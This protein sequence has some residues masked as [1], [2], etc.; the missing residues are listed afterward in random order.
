M[1]GRVTQERH[2][3]LLVVSS[4][5]RRG[6]EV[7]TSQLWRGLADRGW[8]V[9]AVSLTRS[10]GAATVDIPSLTDV[11]PAQAGRLNTEVLRALRRRVGDSSPA[12]VV[13]M[14]GPTLRYTALATA[15]RPT[16]LVYFAIGEPRYWLSSQPIIMLNRGLYRMTDKIIAVSEMTAEQLVGIEPAIRGRVEVAY[17][18]VDDTMFAVSRPPHDG[19]IRLLFVGSLSREKDPLLS[20]QVLSQ[21]LDAHLRFVGDGPLSGEVQAVAEELGVAARVTLSGSVDDIRDDLAW[22]DL[23]LLTSR[24]EGLPG[25][26]LEAAAAGV[27]TVAVDVGGLGEAVS[28]GVTGLLVTREVDDIA[29]AIKDLAANPRRIAEM[30]EAAR[31]RARDQF[32]LEKSI[33]RFE[34]ILR[35]V[36]G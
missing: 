2:G 13:A 3:I 15:V 33:D 21:L 20:V 23:L 24:T 25:V 19:P 22:A 8:P 6:A 32:S 11:D 31:E 14:G 1:A 12:L 9:D 29:A 17:T 16:K 28:H 7:F 18:G 36:V 27:P 26:V 10:T 5:R 35:S 30:G 4:D 34:T